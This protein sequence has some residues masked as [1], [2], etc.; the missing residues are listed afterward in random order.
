MS[1]PLPDAGEVLIVEDTPASLKL[2]ADLLAGAGYVVRQA[3]DG[4]LAL[5][6]ARAR[7]PELI[8]L[9]V[10]MPGIDGFEVCRRLKEDPALRAIPVIFLSAQSDTDDKINGFRA[11][12]IDFIGKP[13]QSEEVLART[14]AHLALSR[15]QRALAA[16]NAELTETLA[17]LHAARDELRRT[18]R[19]AALG[20]MVAGMAHELNTPIGNCMMS[21]S[22]LEQRTREFGEAAQ[23]GLR[24][25]DLAQYIDDALLAS[26]LIMRNL[27]S[28]AEL[29][30]R[31]KEVATD[32]ASVVRRR[33]DL[34]ALLA[35]VAASFA[36]RLRGTGV[37]LE[38]EA[39]PALSMD[40]FPGAL[41]EVLGHLLA[42]A[43]VHG[44]ADGASGT[45]SIRARE[46][47]G[48]LALAV[49]DDGAG[50]GAAELPRVFEPFFT[51]RMGQGSTGLGLHIA[52]NLVANVLGGTLDV[53]SRPG[54]TVFEL[55]CPA[56]APALD[57][58]RA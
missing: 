42:N 13:Y 7:P 12:G 11:G 33:F 46:Q 9:D 21:A 2:L 55:R 54:C 22:T 26:T 47:G 16:S 28:S 25:S 29:I 40:S 45:I 56:R 32:Q 38:I 39:V 37:H 8:L 18:E 58:P 51:T 53:S 30:A 41:G 35:N 20:S 49:C 57:A 52:H 48:A 5:W 44:Y 4:E 14:G 23:A 6:S 17:Q 31:F 1:A 34:D 10:R 36:P 15:S 19:L 3:P 27:R 24:R 50:I 43:L